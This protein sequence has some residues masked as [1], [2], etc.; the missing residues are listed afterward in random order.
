MRSD[1]SHTPLLHGLSMERGFPVLADRY[2]TMQPVVFHAAELFGQNG[3]L[4][5]TEARA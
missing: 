1:N 4:R 3:R 2:G 5:L